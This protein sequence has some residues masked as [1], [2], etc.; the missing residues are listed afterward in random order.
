MSINKKKAA[1]IYRQYGREDKYVSYLETHL[2]KEKENYLELIEYYQKHQESEQA[3]QVGERALEKCKEDLTDIFIFLL[4]DALEHEELK[5]YNKL[6]ASAKRRRAAN[7]VRID[8][9]LPQ[10]TH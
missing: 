8:Q 1:Q 6:Y 9:A 7:I 3:R 4:K 10:F 2:G 5:R